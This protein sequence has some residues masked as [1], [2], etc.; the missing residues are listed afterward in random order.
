MKKILSL[1]TLLTISGT[2][3]PM[4]VAAA[5]HQQTNN[6]ETLKRNKRQSNNIFTTGTLNFDFDVKEYFKNL[7][8]VIKDLL[9]KKL[10]W[11]FQIL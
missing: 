2:T 11:M 1:L 4:V 9:E 5:P 8:K 6:L 7:C 10:F 3:M